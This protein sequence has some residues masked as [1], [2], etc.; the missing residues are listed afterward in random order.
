GIRNFSDYYQLRQE[1]AAAL[2]TAVR[3]ATDLY[4][5]GK[6]SYLEVITAQRNALDAE[7]EVT[8]ARKNIL[9][10]SISLYRSLGGGWR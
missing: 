8:Q 6:A 9:L 10:R 1:E 4:R 2:T 5:V 3:V 7:L